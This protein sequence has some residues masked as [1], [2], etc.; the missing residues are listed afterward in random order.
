MKLLRSQKVCA[1]N[2]LL[3]TIEFQFRCFQSFD[4]YKGKLKTA[5]SIEHIRS[6]MKLFSKKI[7]KNFFSGPKETLV[8]ILTTMMVIMNHHLSRHNNPDNPLI[9]FY[10]ETDTFANDREN[11]T[12]CGVFLYSMLT[13]AFQ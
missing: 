10:F 3:K 12:D 6:V 11:L 7:W 1:I 9:C 13:F 2:Y 4:A 8:M 5:L